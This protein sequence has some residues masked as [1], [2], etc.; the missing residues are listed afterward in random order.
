[1]SNFV[2]QL[3]FVLALTMKANRRAQYRRNWAAAARTLRQTNC[4]TTHS[5]HEDSTDLIELPFNPSPFDD[6]CESEPDN[7]EPVLKRAYIGSDENC[8]STHD[9]SNNLDE[10]MPDPYTDSDLEDDN[11]GSDSLT[12][13]LRNWANNFLIKHNALDGLLVLLKRN[14]HPNLP[15]TARTLLQ[16]ERNTTIQKKSGME[17]VYLPLAS[18][19][20]KHFKKYPSQIIDATNSLEISLNVDGL[21]LF[22][23]SRTSL[24]PVLCAVVNLKPVVV[25]P[26]V[27]TCGPSKPN[28]LEFLEELI[29]DLDNILDNGLQDDGRLIEVSLRCIVCDAPARALVEGTK[30]CS[31]YFGCDKCKQKG[32]WIGRVTY[33]LVKGVDLRTDASFRQQEDEEHH[34]STSPFC[35]LPIDM[36]KTFPIDYMHQLCLGVMRKLVL[37]W[38]RG[39]REVKMSAGQVETISNKLVDLKSCI[40]NTFARKPRSL[41]DVDRWKATEFLQFLLY[42][43]KIVL[44]GTLKQEQF[45]HFLC[46]SVASCIL[47]CPTLAK[48]HRDYAKQLMEYF[49]EQ[50]KILYGDEFLVYNVHSMVHLADE[51]KEF[52]SLD[53]CSSFP[54]ENYMQKLKRLVRSG[55]NPISQV[56]KRM[57]ESSGVIE[58]IDDAT[59]SLKKP[60]NAFLLTGPS[61]CEVVNKVGNVDENGNETYLC[62]VYERTD[63]LFVIPCDSRLIGVH[64]GNARRTTMKVLHSHLLTKK[65]IKIDL[66]PDKIVFMAVLH[67]I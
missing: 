35:N 46:L 24:W 4:D 61:C 65:A 38:M 12:E 7:L 52:G 30:L 49:V 17:Y 6:N 3:L 2:A 21:P 57:S 1:M 11:L 9:D 56:A 5:E 22:K 34:H 63:A 66:G 50:G 19:L 44:N 16:T 51:V 29:R 27:L 59:I 13:G 18:Q 62:R 37:T 53:A 60:D 33:P 10:I 54:F 14:G 15:V 36:I 26:V 42:T 67:T 40:P 41:S 45:E 31:G 28:D 39:K 32:L 25:F 48:L 20:L 55:K 23:R 47:V 8:S 58:P 43:G 64:K